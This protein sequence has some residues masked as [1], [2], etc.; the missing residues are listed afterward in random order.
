[1][2]RCSDQLSRLL[3]ALV[4]DRLGTMAGQ[5]GLNIVN[6]SVFIETTAILKIGNF[7]SSII[8]TPGPGGGGA[9]WSGRG[10]AR[11]G[12]CQD[13]TQPEDSEDSDG[14][15]GHPEDGAHQVSVS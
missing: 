8:F 12:Q 15:P 4:T 2:V 3:S 11:S 5:A 13:W 7:P 10:E 14:G 9:A 6:A 1:M